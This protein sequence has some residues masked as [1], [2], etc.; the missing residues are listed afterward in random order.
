MWIFTTMPQAFIQDRSY[1]F[2]SFI[3]QLTNFSLVSQVS[4]LIFIGAGVYYEGPKDV[5]QT[6]K[7]VSYVG[8]SHSDFHAN[9]I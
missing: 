4:K 9:L 5:T 8:V 1:K 6:P 7:F 2:Q 3:F